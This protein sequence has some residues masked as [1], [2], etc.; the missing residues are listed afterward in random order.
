ME[1]KKARLLR[2]GRDCCLGRGISLFDCYDWSIAI[3]SG[4]GQS[5]QMAADSCHR[6]SRIADWLVRE[7][8]M[9]DW[10]GA[11]GG[12]IS[13]ASEWL[14]LRLDVS[15]VVREAQIISD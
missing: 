8:N 10:L 5:G 14:V 3:Q 1:V 11:E 2:E 7:W 13:I 9:M 15:G 12:F 4:L 6:R